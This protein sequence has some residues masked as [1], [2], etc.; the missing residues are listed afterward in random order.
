M[1]RNL[2]NVAYLMATDRACEAV[3]AGIRHA[4]WTPPPAAAEPT[5]GPNAP[6]LQAILDRAGA[7]PLD[8]VTAKEVLRLYGLPTPGEG[9]ATSAEAAVRLAE[10][11]GYPIVLK[12]V[13][14]AIPHKTEAGGVVLNLADAAAVR[15]GYAA[16]M[17]S[18]KA[19][20]RPEEIAG[21]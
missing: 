15:A 10:R 16:V 7:G 8:E 12:I 19:H 3:A 14:P 11:I 9:L 4:A 17:V 2:T 13:S 20:A 5:P 1:R 18:A 6:R 21:V